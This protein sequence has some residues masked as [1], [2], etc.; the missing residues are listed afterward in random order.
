MDDIITYLQQTRVG[1]HVT[2]TIVRD[3]QELALPVEL[4]E[5]PPR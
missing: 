1:Q 3:G 2:L 5:R 4:G